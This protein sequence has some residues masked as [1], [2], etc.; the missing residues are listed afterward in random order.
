MKVYRYW[1]EPATAD[2]ARLLRQQLARAANYRRELA[3]IENLARACQRSILGYPKDDRAAPRREVQAAQ[4]AATKAARDLARMSGPDGLGCAWGTC[5]QV[6]DAADHSQRTTKIWSDVSTFAARDEGL[7]AVQYQRHANDPKWEPV[8]ASGLVGGDDTFVQIGGELVGKPKRREWVIEFRSGSYFVSLGRDTGGTASEAR[9]FASEEEAERYL[10]GMPFGLR[11]AGAMVKHVP[12]AGAARLR[13]LRFRVGSDG[14][15]PIWA[16]LYTLM[17]RPLPDARVTWVKLSCRRVG[18]R[19]RWFLLVVVDEECRGTPDQQR[20]TAVGVDIGW[21]K[22]EDGS[23]RIAC[24][25]GSDGRE[26]ELAI[27][28]VV[29]RRKGKSDSLK[30]IRDRERN[31]V[32]ALWRR[33]IFGQDMA[34]EV[35]DD[36]DK[37]ITKGIPVLH[38]VREA[39]RSMHSWTR[40]GRFVVLARLW[41]GNRIEGDAAIYARVQEW[42]KHDRHL[43]AWEANNRRRM[44]LEVAARVDNLAVQLAR[45]YEMIAVE[46]RGMV[47]ELVRKDAGN[48]QEEERIR[49]LSAS[50]VGLVAPAS[51]RAALERFA[52]KYGALYREVNP[53][54][55]TRDCATCGAERPAPDPADVMMGCDKCGVIEDQDLTAARNIMVRASAEV[56]QERAEALAP[57]S[58]GSKPKR[59]GPRRTRRAVVVAPLENASPNTDGA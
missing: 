36:S 10:N 7:L 2:D 41:E 3:R 50:R 6:D 40:M 9:R 46:D 18:L 37:T 57:A 4:R 56:Q 25:S 45:Q 49:A 51:L 33:W 44:A 24:W 14:R 54:Y 42:L 39:A 59:M 23:I 32:S 1:A 48:D 15:K 29:H 30:S 21:R 22:R 38:P 34:A 55:T 11:A 17:H 58:S 27:E 28:E 53:A 31:E 26:G 13:H 43:Y 5:G 47:P 19:Y 35:P 8:L 52:T 12:G 20:G 16:N